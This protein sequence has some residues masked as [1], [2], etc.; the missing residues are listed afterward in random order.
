MRHFDVHCW[1]GKSSWVYEAFAI[2]G[3]RTW[4]GAMMGVHRYPWA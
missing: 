2:G 4:P 1:A 3:H